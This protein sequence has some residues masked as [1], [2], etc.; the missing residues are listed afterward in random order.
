MISPLKAEP[1]YNPGGGARRALRARAARALSLVIVAISSAVFG[2]GVLASRAAPDAFVV[3][4]FAAA[5]V[6][7]IT[8][9]VVAMWRFDSD[10]ARMEQ[11]AK[12]E[13]AVGQF[14]ERYHAVDG[15]RLFHHVPFDRFDIDH[16]LVHRTGVYAIET[17]TLSK[18][19]GSSARLLYDGEQVAFEN[20]RAL[21][22]NPVIQAT[23]NARAASDL[24][25][26]STGRRIQVRPVVLFPGWWI[27]ARP[28]AHRRC[29]VLNPKSLDSFL[30]S[31]TERLTPEDVSLIAFHL[32]R[33]I[34][35]EAKRAAA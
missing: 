16:V 17:K 15:A 6:I 25:A 1:L 22:R 35:S 20:G 21:E 9:L 19:A 4:L 18:R 31:R 3:A 23:A 8:A 24:I 29:W 12:G 30:T 32:G 11:G 14:L 5:V 13:T 33:Y 7:A 27:D 26:E 2:L 34:R 10:A 28:G